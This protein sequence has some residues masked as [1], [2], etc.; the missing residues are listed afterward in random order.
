MSKSSEWAL[1]MRE[2]E[3]LENPG[4]A[5]DYYWFKLWDGYLQRS[6]QD[7]NKKMRDLDGSENSSRTG[8]LRVQA[9]TKIEEKDPASFKEDQNK[10]N[11]KIKK[12][13]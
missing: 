5:D 3:I 2:K 6:I 11:T 13:D 8:L 4:L 7:Q 1:K 12:N 9:G 10:S